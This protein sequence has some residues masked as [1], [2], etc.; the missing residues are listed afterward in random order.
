MHKVVTTFLRRQ[1]FSNCVPPG[2]LSSEIPIGLLV[3]MW[4][5][6]KWEIDF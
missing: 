6:D 1:K 4:W 5:A 2:F 3:G